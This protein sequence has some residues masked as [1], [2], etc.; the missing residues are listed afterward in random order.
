MPTYANTICRPDLP[1]RMRISALIRVVEGTDGRLWKDFHEYSMAST[2]GK[3]NEWI[4]GIFNPKIS[5]FAFALLQ[6]LTTL[7]YNRLYLPNCCA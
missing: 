4:Y 7:L 6:K 2:G 3:V 5:R 1:W